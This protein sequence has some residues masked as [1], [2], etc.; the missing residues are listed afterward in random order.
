MIVGWR[1]TRSMTV[2][3]TLDA[4]EQALRAKNIEEGLIHH[5]DRG[6]PVS[7]NLIF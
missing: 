1:V 5:S 6:K 4:L 2:D 7:C 3:L